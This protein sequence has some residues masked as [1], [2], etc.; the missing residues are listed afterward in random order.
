M[1]EIINK[2]NSLTISEP[3]IKTDIDDLCDNLSMLKI[4]TDIDKPT[5]EVFTASVKETIEKTETK[6]V[7]ELV[8]II[9][10]QIYLLGK[11]LAMRGRCFFEQKYDIPKYIF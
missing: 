9:K 3:T 10:S 1:D 11:I 4:N 2:L 7:K 5:L 8:S 6:P